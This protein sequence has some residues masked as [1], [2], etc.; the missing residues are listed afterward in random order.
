M[1]TIY[2]SSDN[3]L[4]VTDSIEDGIWINLVTPTELEIQQASDALSVDVDFVRAALDE[5]ERSRIEL[6]EESGNVLIVVD[7]PLVEFKRDSVVYETYP[8][9]IVYT[10][11]GVLTVSLKETI[12]IKNFANSNVKTFY[13]YKKSRFVLQ[14]LYRNAALFL[15]HLKQI[16]RHSNNILSKL[17]KTMMNKELIQLMELEKSLVYFSTSLRANELVI[18][19][20]LRYDFIKKYPEDYEL[21]EDIIT[22]NKQAIEMAK[23]Y[24]DILSSTMVAL[25]SLISNN[26]N[27]SLKLLSAIVSTVGIPLIITGFMSM[28]MPNPL[29]GSAL[30]FW[31]IIALC[32]FL[33]TGLLYYL[34]KKKKP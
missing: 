5:E 18:E 27:I 31:L 15:K 26:I 4:N 6:D 1:M 11:T 32:V 21:L 30:G 23:I 25:T 20:L 13:T 33:C 12:V 16:D 34:F 7:I 8:L 22:E 2:K 29:Q 10:S 9:G 17:H 24:S 28:N 14:I 19:K 3:G